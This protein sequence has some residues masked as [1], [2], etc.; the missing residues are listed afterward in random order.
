MLC[1]CVCT[2]GLPRMESKGEITRFNTRLRWVVKRVQSRGTHWWEEKHTLAICDDVCWDREIGSTG[3]SLYLTVISRVTLL[4]TSRAYGTM[5]NHGGRPRWSI[6]ALKRRDHSPLRESPLCTLHCGCGCQWK[7]FHQWEKNRFSNGR[8]ALA[9]GISIQP[10]NPS[11]FAGWKKLRIHW[12]V[13]QPQRWKMNELRL[14]LSGFHISLFSFLSFS[15][16]FFPIFFFLFHYCWSI[17]YQISILLLIVQR[18]Y[19][20]ILL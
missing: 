2:R 16:S 12:S 14:L 11:F 4:N 15:L 3:L 17:E 1:V 5:A 20:L 8:V 6:S 10:P 7:V 13:S 19:E 9:T 18:F